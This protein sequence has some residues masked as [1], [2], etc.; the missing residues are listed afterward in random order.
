MAGDLD[1]RLGYV[2]D[3]DL[4]LKDAGLVAADA[5]AQV[6]GTNRIVDLGDGIFHGVVMFNATAVEIADNDELYEVYLQGSTKSDFADTIVNLAMYPFGA[7]EAMAANAD[8]DV[9]VGVHYLPFINM[10]DD[11]IYRYVRLFTDVTGTVGTGI[12]FEAFIGRTHRVI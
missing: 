3:A 11:T 12:N 10:Q 6:G 2:F 7:L 9:G 1:K 4:Q 8:Q 5:A